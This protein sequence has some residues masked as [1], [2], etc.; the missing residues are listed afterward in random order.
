V[1]TF[2]KADS[3][4]RG[5]KQLSR[6]DQQRFLAALRLFIEDLEARDAGRV[7]RAPFRPGLRV[8]QVRGNRG[9]WEMSWAPDGRATFAYGKQ[10]L[11]GA[12]H[13]IWLDIGGHEI[14]P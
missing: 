12:T 14:L 7:S 13:I 5:Y 10:I 6:Q 3:F 1:P 4:R 9:V 2:D 11:E 8:K